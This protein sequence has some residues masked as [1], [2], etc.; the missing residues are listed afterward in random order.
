MEIDLFDV[1]YLLL[2]GNCYSL[3]HSQEK[4]CMF[5]LWFF[6]ICLYTLPSEGRVNEEKGVTGK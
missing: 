4:I 6:H 3:C 2:R 5:F 1:K